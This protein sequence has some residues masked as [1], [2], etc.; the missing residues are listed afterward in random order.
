MAFP[1]SRSSHWTPTL[2]L[3]GRTASFAGIRTRT[4]T[5]PDSSPSTAAEP[6]PTGLSRRG[7]IDER[8]GGLQEGM[9]WGG[10]TAEGRS[11]GGLG[12]AWAL[13][14]GSAERDCGQGRLSGGGCAGREAL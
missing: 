5:T 1:G 4:K 13:G 8:R 12:E 6:Q 10:L 2:I 3:V 14:G 7:A 11:S 9:D